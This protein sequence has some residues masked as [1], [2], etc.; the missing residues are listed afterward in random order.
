[1]PVSDTIVH[2]SRFQFAFLRHRKLSAYVAD[3]EFKFYLSI[4]VFVSLLIALC[5]ISYGMYDYHHS[6][7]NSI[8]TTVSIAST[9]GFTNSD[10]NLWPTFVPYL[11]MFVALIGGCGG[12]TSGGIKVM[13]VLMLKEQGKRELKRLVHPQAVYSVKYGKEVLPDSIIQS[14]W[15][16]VAV[17]TAI[18]VILFLALLACGLDVRTAFG[19]LASSMSNTGAAIGKVSEVYTWISDTTKWILIFSMIVGR[20]EVFTILVLFTSSYWRK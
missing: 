17:F 18:F 11:L 5:L 16:F 2:L 4:L 10:F 1:M 20:L 9:T 7:L 6:I 3:S 15:A 14:I 19:A 8:F 13:R 12:S